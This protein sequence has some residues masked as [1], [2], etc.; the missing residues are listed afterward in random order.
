MRR[1]GRLDRP[2]RIGRN[3]AMRKMREIAAEIQAKRL[4]LKKLLNK[5]QTDSGDELTETLKRASGLRDEITPLD[6]EL[7]S[8]QAFEAPA[9]GAEGGFPRPRGS[10]WGDRPLDPWT[11]S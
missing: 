10:I 2:G 8:A 1:G 4:E 6:A 11:G 3:Q 9:A 5:A 7:K